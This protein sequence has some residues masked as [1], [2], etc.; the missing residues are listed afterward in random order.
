M[1]KSVISVEDIAAQNVKDQKTWRDNSNY[2]I[3]KQEMARSNG[4]RRS[5][6]AFRART[7]WLFCCGNY[8]Q[9]SVCGEMKARVRRIRSV[10]TWMSYRMCKLWQIHG[11]VE[12]LSPCRA[13][14][15]EYNSSK[16]D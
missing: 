7:D 6:V 8:T 2:Q 4:W 5:G 9:A 11:P 16:L 1:R 3:R 13:I 15:V 12:T 14:G 10:G